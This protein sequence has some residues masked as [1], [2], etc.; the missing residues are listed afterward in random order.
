MAPLRCKRWWAAETASL[1]VNFLAI[2]LTV[3]MEK[4]KLGSAGILAV[5][6]Q[7]DPSRGSERCLDFDAFEFLVCFQIIVWLLAASARIYTVQR[8]FWD[9]FSAPLK[10]TEKVTTFIFI[11]SLILSSLRFTYLPKTTSIFLLS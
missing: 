1:K 6:E 9:Q 2:L 8:G 11:H 10:S 7:P 4:K 3:T 5:G